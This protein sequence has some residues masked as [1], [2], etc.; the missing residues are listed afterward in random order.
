MRHPGDPEDLT[1][2]FHAPIDYFTF[3]TDRIC[4]FEL[5]FKI[6]E[7]SLFSVNPDLY[8]VLSCFN[9]TSPGFGF[10][11][12]T[13]LRDLQKCKDH[14]CTALLPLIIIHN[15]CYFADFSAA[16]KQKISRI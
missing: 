2:M 5:V 6:R 4:L 9:K 16:V 15:H 14:C 8:R 13:R 7:R 10:L 1:N 3:S 12:L 11:P